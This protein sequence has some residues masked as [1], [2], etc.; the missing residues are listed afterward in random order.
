LLA[1]FLYSTF[2]TIVHNN[3]ID[4]K[5]ASGIISACRVY[6]SWLFQAFGNVRD[7][8]G[9]AVKMDWIPSNMSISSSNFG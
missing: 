4:L 6:F 1:V 9:N 7:L 2:S 5:T 3:S 8:T